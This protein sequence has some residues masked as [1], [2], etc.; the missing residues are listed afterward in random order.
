MEQSFKDSK[1]RFGLAKVQVGC[2]ARLTRLLAALTLA[3]AWLA[4]LTLPAGQHLP[5]GWRPQAVAWGRPS[6]TTLALAF[7]DSG[8]DTACPYR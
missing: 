7:L 3:L 6:T 2:P 1:S 5:P 8:G 4:L